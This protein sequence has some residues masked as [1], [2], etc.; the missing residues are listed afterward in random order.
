M[1]ATAATLAAACTKHEENKCSA[2]DSGSC[3]MLVAALRQA[4]DAGAVR[5]VCALV[6]SVTTADDPRPPASRYVQG[7]IWNAV[8]C[9]LIEGLSTVCSGNQTGLS[10]AAV[11]T[12]PNVP[13][14]CSLEAWQ[15]LR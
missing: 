3:S 12:S 7:L 5:A 14:A 8:V 9:L 10:Q 11:H 15:C 13:A 2:V 4:P 1:E 6:R